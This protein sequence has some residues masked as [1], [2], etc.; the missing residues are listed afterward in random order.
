MATTPR[1]PKG[2]G[3]PLV[4]STPLT[5][6]QIDQLSQEVQRQAQHELHAVEEAIVEEAR[7]PKQRW[8]WDS[9]YAHYRPTWFHAVVLLAAVGTSAAMGYLTRPIMERQT[10]MTAIARSMAVSVPVVRALEV[11]ADPGKYQ[12]RLVDVVMNVTRGGLFR[13]GKGL[14]LQEHEGGMALTIFAS[15]FDQF[16]GEGGKPEDIPAK[17]IGKYIRARGIVTRFNDRVSMIIYAPGLM[18]EI[19]MP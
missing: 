6:A 2:Q 13:S 4:M 14:Y 10:T 3:A 18:S 7:I 8:T 15:A 9:G 16:V 17:Y 1:K 19:P 5:P 11:S 12:G